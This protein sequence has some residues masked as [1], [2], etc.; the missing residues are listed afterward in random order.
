[1]NNKTSFVK[2]VLVMV[3]GTA[4]AQ[5]ISFLAIP[6]ITRMYGPEAYGILGV[7]IAVAALLIPISALTYPIAIVL[8]NSQRRAEKIASVSI[9]TTILLT[10]FILIIISVFK[11]H[12]L[13]IFNLEV[14]GNYIFLLPLVILFSGIHQTLEQWNIRELRYKRLAN[15]TAIHSIIH[16]S[17]IIGLGLISPFHHILIIMETLKNALKAILISFKSFSIYNVKNILNINFKKL[18]LTARNYKDFPIYR[19]PEVLLSSSSQAIPI[20]LLSS[21]FGPSVV[22]F[23]TLSKTVLAAPTQLIGKSIGDVIYPKLSNAFNESRDIQK[24]VTKSTLYLAVLGVLPFG[25]V[26]LFGPQLFS[27]VFGEEWNMAGEFARW[28]SL[29]SYCLFI[30]IPAVKAL[31]VLSAQAFHL[32]F[33]VILLIVR[34]FSMIFAYHF[35]QNEIEVVKYAAISSSILNIFLILITIKLSKNLNSK[36]I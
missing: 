20:L 14:I 22:G 2:N 34:T 30:N 1:M 3:S 10:L 7:Y 35:T 5:I 25:I 15:A 26:I 9:Y 21:F 32:K 27:L 33:T 12:L 16:N 19:A 31:P 13:L 24:L 6:V 29:W 36:Q 17:M 28:L 8:P 23:Y 18:F 11:N 4:I